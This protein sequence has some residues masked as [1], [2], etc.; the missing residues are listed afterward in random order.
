MKTNKII[1]PLLMIALLCSCGSTDT[2]SSDSVKQSEI[3]QSYSLNYNAGDR[4][5]SATASFRFGGSTG[6]TLKLDGESSV[7]LNGEKMSPEEGIFTGTFYSTD[8]QDDFSGHYSFRYID[9]DQKSYTNIAVLT[10]LSIT[11]YPQNID[12]S[13]GLMVKWDIPLKENESITLYMEDGKNN[14]ATSTISNIGAGSI[15]LS[16]EQMNNI[17]PGKVN[18]YLTRESSSALKECTHLGGDLSV[19]YTSKKVSV[20]L[21]GEEPETGSKN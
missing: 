19:K 14:I 11:E 4:E 10:P 16:P 6:T 21:S 17:S 15:E 1:F 20:T 3:Y 5:M 2:A 8:K 12:K 13:T 18:L 7:S 9:G